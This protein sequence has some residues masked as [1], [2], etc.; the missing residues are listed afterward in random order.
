M[1]GARRRPYVDMVEEGNAAAGAPQR[2]AGAPVSGDAT[3]KVRIGPW[4]KRR[5]RPASGRT[6]A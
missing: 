5:A 6:Y 2:G 1:Q 3:A 4:F